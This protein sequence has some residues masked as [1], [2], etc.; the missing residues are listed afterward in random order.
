MTLE[1]D[2][3]DHDVLLL[4]SLHGVVQ[5]DVVRAE[6]HGHVHAVGEHQHH[7]PTFLTKERRH[8]DVHGVPQG[9]RSVRLQLRPEDPDELVL[10]ARELARIHLNPSG[11][12]AD[13]RLVGRQQALDERLPRCFDEPE[14]RLHAPA[15]IEHHDDR[16]RLNIVGEDRDRLELAVVVDLE[17]VS[18]EVR[19]Q[20]SVGAG[21]RRIQRN[22]PRAALEWSL[23]RRHT[24][25]ER[26]RDTAGLKNDSRKE[27][28]AV[29][30]KAPHGRSPDGHASVSAWQ[31]LLSSHS[32][33]RHAE[34]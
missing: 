6:V 10:V 25:D 16:D 30:F 8:P 22:R 18:L 2:G 4:R 21:H 1:P 19:Y 5:A 11:E 28:R 27:G 24:D 26:R 14:V 17:V 13:P 20:A 23:A 9:R 31:A 15:S 33:L 32:Q 12:A 34:R 7:A 29:H 3:V